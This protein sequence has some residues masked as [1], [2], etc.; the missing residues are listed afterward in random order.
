[1][2]CK[3]EPIAPYEYE[4]NPLYADGW[5]NSYGQ[6]YANIPYNVLSL[7]LFTEGMLN[8]KK[9]A[10]VAPGQYLFI[11]DIL[12][13]LSDSTLVPGLYTASKNYEPYTFYPGEVYRAD[14]VN[15]ILGAWIYYVEEE[16]GRS[17]RKL[18]TEGSFT[19]DSSGIRF[20][21]TTADGKKLGGNT[22]N[23]D[24]IKVFMSE[25][26]AK[27]GAFQIDF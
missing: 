6:Y 4:A 5:I 22:K 23:L 20:D 11:E 7:Q 21:L 2:S 25:K 17:V 10:I 18:I 26:A 1:M 3:V 13:P 14:S 24:N 12:V 8:E 16:Y 27:E 19:F 9:D 15:Q